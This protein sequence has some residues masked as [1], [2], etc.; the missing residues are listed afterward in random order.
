MRE[1]LDLAT[2]AAA[3]SATFLRQGWA[4]RTVVA[5]KSS[6]TDI[7]TSRCNS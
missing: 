1:L 6:S 2:R 5:T 4:D 3:D 7:V